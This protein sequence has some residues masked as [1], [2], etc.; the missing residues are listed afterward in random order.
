MASS[1]G[2]APP[3]LTLPSSTG[4]V[5]ESSSNALAVGL[6]DAQQLEKMSYDSPASGETKPAPISPLL[7]ASASFGSWT[8][9]NYLFSK[10][11]QEAPPMVQPTQVFLDLLVGYP[12][13]NITEGR[14]TVQQACKDVEN[15]VDQ[16]AS[17]TT[18]LLLKGVTAM[19]DTALHSVASNGDSNKFLVCASIIIERDQGLLFAVNKM[20]DTPLH[21]AARAGVAKHMVN[22]NTS[23]T[24]YGDSHGITPLHF[25]SGFGG[26]ISN[27]FRQLLE[28]NPAPVY[29]ADNNG[30]FPIHVAASVGTKFTIS[31][32][33]AKFPSSAGL[34]TA[35]GRTFLHVAVERKRLDIVSF[36]CQT[37]SLDWILNMRDNDGNTALHLA[38]RA[39]KLRTFCPLYGNKGVHLSLAN[40]KR[41]TP[42][43]I[44]RTLL[45]HGMHYEWNSDCQIY[46]ALLSG[47]AR[48]SFL[49]PHQTEG[50]YS[51]QSKQKQVEEAEKVKES[52]QILGIGSVLITTVAFG[53]TFAV[54][55]GFIADD[56]T[57][58]GT[59][60][61]A[62]TYTF[63]AFMMANALAFICASI[64]TVGLMFS[65]SPLINLKSR[66]INLN[67]SVYF[68]YSSVTC[69]S[70]AFGLG[71][72]MVLAE[73][74][75]ATG[76]VIC[77]LSPLVA[78]YGG[79]EVLMKICIL[80]QP[81]WVRLG[82]IRASKWLAYTIVSTLLMG[83]WPF[84]VI[85]GWAAI[86][87]KL[88]NH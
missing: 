9:L 59:P 51:N 77:V 36:V 54:P 21:C 27:E 44:A 82:P 28:A 7:L 17:P 38:V 16:P 22:W 24:T 74:A 32:I 5:E 10:E 18:A 40:N 79:L 80:A 48:H 47:G 78:L 70:A 8:A 15:V 11:D 42:I 25:A 75:Q 67:T 20:G 68:L 83:L 71:V 73:V 61:L 46:R 86:A 66:R 56:H 33:L 45:P 4:N 6:W 26:S 1:T 29:Q 34:R 50:N 2:I 84:I 62:G 57:N 60:T 23:L 31:I 35:Q 3:M 43:D 30:F 65:G 85:F 13:G 12:A 53:A 63:D 14:L 64:A 87:R 55:G 39:G 88:R 76:I 72:Y 81:V 58:R 19:G 41:Q 52:S 49:V 69:L 37:P